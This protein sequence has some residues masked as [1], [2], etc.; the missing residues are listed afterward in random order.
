MENPNM[1]IKIF[2]DKHVTILKLDDI[3]L[4]RATDVAAIF[5]IKNIYT[6]VQNFDDDE[7]VLHQVENPNGC[8]KQPVL[9]LTSDGIYRL[10]FNSKKPQ[11]KQFRKWAS[12]ILNDINFNAG[13]ELRKQL[14]QKNKEL[15]TERTK[16]DI[17]QEK[18]KR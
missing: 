16:N 2:E 6:S 7:R 9:F 17:L 11:A 18:N 4:F 3:F 1:I 5:E 14:L 12:N 13:E 8:G 15:E 10:L